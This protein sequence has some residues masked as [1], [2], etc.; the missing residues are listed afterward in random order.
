MSPYDKL[1]TVYKGLVELCLRWVVAIIIIVGKKDVKYRD[2]IAELD[3]RIINFPI[4]HSISPFGDYHFSKGIS[5]LF[6][7]STNRD[8]SALEKSVGQG[9]RVE[10]QRL[11]TLLWQ[12]KCMYSSNVK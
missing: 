1:H 10:A 9:G 8:F 11:A 4:G 12:V 5:V 6:G 3:N 7:E 2:T